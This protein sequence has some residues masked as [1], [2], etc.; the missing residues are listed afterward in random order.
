MEI[1]TITEK[2]KFND[3]GIMIVN[4]RIKFAESTQQEPDSF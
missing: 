3:C 1:V 4:L 2:V